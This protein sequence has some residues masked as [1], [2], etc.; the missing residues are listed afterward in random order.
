MYFVLSGILWWEFLRSHKK[1]FPARRAW[2][3]AC[4]C[5][6]LF[7]GCIELL[8]E[9]CTEHRG[10]EWLDFA[11]NTTGALLASLFAYYV[12]RPRMVKTGD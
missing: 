5:P 10:G 3:G 6:I 8:Q 2:I 7:S 9:Y 11:A 1:I 12:L 4:V